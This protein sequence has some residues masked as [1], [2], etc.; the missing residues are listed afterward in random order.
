M[1]TRPP[2]EAA[3]EL[4]VGGAILV[5]PRACARRA[6]VLLVTRRELAR[7]ARMLLP[8]ARSEV[9][10]LP[11]SGLPLARCIFA[12]AVGIAHSSALRDSDRRSEQ[13]GR[14][15]QCRDLDMHSA[16]PSH[17]C[18]PVKERNP[19]CAVPDF[20]K[21]ATNPRSSGKRRA[22]S[23]ALRNHQKSRSHSRAV[24]RKA[25]SLPSHSEG[26]APAAPP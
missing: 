7:L 6:L 1:M 22:C 23:K 20:R 11:R 10:R 5:H 18:S 13:D 26:T 12:G 16:F 3:S 4:Q 19:T 2:T 25:P 17:C 15:R 24:G 21:E 8:L 14:C 9:S